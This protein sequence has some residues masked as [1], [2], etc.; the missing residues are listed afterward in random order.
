V[1]HHAS[2]GADAYPSTDHKRPQGLMRMPMTGMAVPDHD[3][4]Q[5]RIDLAAAFRF[6][7]DNDWH[8]SVG[9]H[10]SVALQAGSPDFLMNPRWMHFSR[11][12]ASDLIRL[13]ATASAP[14]NAPG[15]PD[16]SAWA[17]H[18]NIHLAMPHVGCILHLHPPYAT[19]VATLADPEILPIDQN[20]ARF[21]ERVAIDRGF[22]G[23][24]DD[25]DEGG[26]LADALGNH[27]IMLM[28]NHGVL[29][30]APTI[31]EAFDD[32]YFLERACKTLLLAYSTGK[33]L[34]VMSPTLA[35]RVAQ[36]WLDYR[37]MP[38]AHFDELKRLLDRRDPS[39][40]D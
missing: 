9:N 27:S 10:F 3:E 11:I 29:V 6:A 40:A 35:R 8:E 18:R 34:K 15:A 37:D 32:L 7:A 14:G 19:A 36:D 1:W 38:F 31:A 23:I 13:D 25:D 26:R 21:Y 30:T 5:L 33:E 16:L 22:G 24:A 20:T 39:Y 17:I 2:A 28:G 12:R 4:R